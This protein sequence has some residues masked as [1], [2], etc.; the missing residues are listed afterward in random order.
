MNKDIDER[1]LP[2]GEYIDAV[3]I[4]IVHAEGADAG[5]ARNMEGNKKL[6]DLSNVAGIP[7]DSSVRTI[8]AVTNDT[9]NTIYFFVTGDKFDGIYEYT[10]DTGLRRILQSNKATPETISKL[11]FKRDYPI[12]GVNYIDGFIYWTD[13]INPPRKIKI[14]RVRTYAIDDS[15]IIEDI[16]V[17]MR[18]PVYAP[19]IDMEEE[20]TDDSQ[21]NNLEEKFV[22]FAYR[23]KYLDDQF[24]AMSPFSGTAFVPDEYF[25]DYGSGENK[26]MLN[27]KKKVNITFETGDNFVVGIELLMRDTKGL[28]IN[29]VEYFDKTDASLG[30]LNNTVFDFA[31]DNSKVYRTLPTSQLFRLYDN[32][33]LKA[34]AQ[35]IVSRRIVYGNYTQG[36]DLKRTN[37]DG[38]E[39][40]VF[41]DYKVGYESKSTPIDTPIQ[42]FRSDRDYEAAIEYLDD[43]G[44]STT[45]LTSRFNTAYIKPE[46]SITGNSLTIDIKNKP[47]SFATDYRVLIKQS[48]GNYYN[49]FPILY[50]TYGAYRYFLINKH[51]VDKIIIGGYVIFKASGT[52]ATLSNKRY[53][54]LEIDVKGSGFLGANSSVNAVPGLYFKIK[55]DNN[56]EFDQNDM[57]ILDTTR[58]GSNYLDTYD[59][60]NENLDYGCVPVRDRIKHAD[61]AI[62]YGDGNPDAFEVR[63]LSWENYYLGYIDLRFTIK[64]TSQTTYTVSSSND[65]ETE[66]QIIP[67][68]DVMIKYWYTIDAFLMRFNNQSS[69]SVGDVWKVN[70]RGDDHLNQGIWG[71]GLPR[72]DQSVVE[73]HVVI[74]GGGAV[75]PGIPDWSNT[76]SAGLEIDKPIKPGSV[77]RITIVKDQNNTSVQE[78]VQQFPPASQEF[79]NIEEWFHES[80]AADNFIQYD[81][82]GNDIGAA[83]VNFCRVWDF[84]GVNLNGVSI[85]NGQAYGDDS[86]SNGIHEYPVQMIIRGYGGFT[87]GDN[88]N[89]TCNQIVARLEIH[90]SENQSICETVP[91][92]NDVEIYHETSRT[93]P[94]VDGKHTV[95]WKFEDFSYVPGGL[96]TRLGTQAG[97]NPASTSR[98]HV[99]QVG[100]K[101]EVNSSEPW[102]N[103][104]FTILEV[105]NKYDIIIDTPNG[106]ATAITPGTVGFYHENYLE[107]DQTDTQA[108]SLMINATSNT[109]STFNAYSFGNGLES[110]RIRDSFNSTTLDYS[111]RTDIAIEDYRQEVKKTSLCYSGMYREDSSLNN[112]NE[113]N[114]SDSNF[115]NL[116]T[117]WGSVQ[118]LYAR[119]T[120]ILVL[121]EDKVSKVLTH[122][123]LLSDAVGGGTIT[124]IPQVLGTQVASPGEWGI[125]YNPESFAQWGKDLFW[126]DT[127][128]GAVLLMNDSG[129]RDISDTGMKD[130]F[131]DEFKANPNNRR[132]GVY[133]PYKHEYVLSTNTDSAAACYLYVSKS[134]FSFQA[135]MSDWYNDIFS[136][137]S[138]SPNFTIFSNEFWTMSLNYINGSNWITGWFP[139]GWGDS[140]V[141]LIVADNNTGQVR[142]AEFTITYCG[143]KELIIKITQ[144]KGRKIN[145][146]TV[147]SGTVN[148]N[149]KFP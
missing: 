58:T 92:D 2:K 107:R 30:V 102:L 5:T 9:A 64:I 124:S 105:P 143:G 39:V 66:H 116:E 111:P 59:G 13:N 55:V 90:Q 48:K 113:F 67:G 103:G 110:D 126:T 52:G 136:A 112:L 142:R 145:V 63:N 32:V 79:A 69:Y 137:P 119:D 117:E 144:A 20:D 131:R 120:D 35:D 60:T 53:K 147:I 86:L 34:K 29:I 140:D 149:T 99:F 95:L 8:G 72:E 94:I 41:I 14:S 44:R 7:T 135:K 23:W 88:D 38:T 82:E 125:S 4:D 45:V 91:L 70:C 75:L 3:N 128:R 101:V 133:D 57:T 31:F 18:P 78:P 93:Y 100:D 62:H 84:S 37:N 146:H 139:S 6:G 43:Y 65:P 114:L 97:S 80:G 12:T 49:V 118:K 28:N 40:P 24:S 121:Q 89:G 25:L 81:G 104:V 27:T 17:I 77:V 16:S 83:G 33:P 74:Y 106:S 61:K 85:T 68:Q 76:N 47:P 22:Q 36:Y 98:P 19:T 54:I 122:K 123:N 132:I 1:I 109:N 130:Y 73:D 42:T 96:Y 87:D 56:T 50:Y 134:D 148:T 108:A 11:N 46:N 10:A 127:R 115:K 26:S 129:I 15:R 21:E 51:D 138:D 141:S 71:V